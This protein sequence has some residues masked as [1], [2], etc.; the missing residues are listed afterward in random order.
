MITHKNIGYS[1]RLGNQMF[2]YAFMKI[3][4]FKT[5]QSVILP[6][7]TNSKPDGFFNFTTNQWCSQRL[8]LLDCFD[9]DCKIGESNEE[10]NIFLEGYFQKYSYLEGYEDEIIKEFTFKS[11][12]LDKS[13]Q[14][15]NKYPNPVSIHIRRG[16]YVA[17]PGFW[18]ITPEYI[19]SALNYFEDEEYTFLVFSDDIKWCKQ[20]FPEGVIF[21]EGNNQFEDLCMM[22]LCY[23]N[24]IA[25]STFSWWG[26]FLNK[27]KNKKIIAPKNWFTDYKP[28]DDLYPDNW[29]II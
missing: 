8:D 16:D 3:L 14:I 29:T 21:M 15:I 13:Q 10:D 20:V 4:S 28:L 24:V 18:N 9:L 5:N 7:N 23:H 27:N 25:N 19:Q 26:A 11:Y 22:S 12:I 6:N 1:G 17:H 2:Q